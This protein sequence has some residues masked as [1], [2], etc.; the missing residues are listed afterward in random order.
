VEQDRLESLNIDIEGRTG[1]LQQWIPVFGLQL[2]QTRRVVV[3][4]ARN[5]DVQTEGKAR[6]TEGPTR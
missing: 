6:Y 2:Y 3:M 4:E 1:P 5:R